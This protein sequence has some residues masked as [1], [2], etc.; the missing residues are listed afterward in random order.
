V[1]NV[2][3]GRNKESNGGIAQDV[4]VVDDIVLA[5][6]FGAKFFWEI[7]LEREI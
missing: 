3:I 6:V 7:F 4:R 5:G 2:G 1:G